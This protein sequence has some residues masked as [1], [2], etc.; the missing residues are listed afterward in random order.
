MSKFLRQDQSLQIK[1]NEADDY[2]FTDGEDKIGNENSILSKTLFPQVDRDEQSDALLV[3]CAGFEDTRHPMYDLLASFFTQK[4]FNKAQ[5]M[6]IVVVES[7][8]RMRLSSDRTAFMRSIKQLAKLLQGEVAAFRDS[9]GLVATKAD[10]SK[11]DEQLEKSVNVFLK[12][13]TNSLQE[14]RDDALEMGE[15][16]E[17]QSLE[18]QILLVQYLAAGDKVAIFRRPN[19][20]QS[21]WTQ[22]P[23]KKNFNKIRHLMLQNLHYLN[24]KNQK[25]QVSVAPETVIYIQSK[26]F[27][28]AEAKLKQILTDIGNSIILELKASSEKTEGTDLDEDVFK[29]RDS[30]VKYAAQTTA[31][32][33]T[34]SLTEYFRRS[35]I[36]ASLV[37]AVDL[38]MRKVEFLCEV[39]GSSVDS[40]R[41]QVT[42]MYGMWG[43]IQNYI[44]ENKNFL[45]AAAKLVEK[46]GSYKIYA[47][48][49]FS[50][51]V[52]SDNYGDFMMYLASLNLDASSFLA[53][54]NLKPT[55][56]QLNLLNRIKT[57]QMDHSIA[58]HKK[59][60]FVTYTGKYILATQI[61][62][63]ETIKGELVIMA[64]HKFFIDRD[65]TLTD[66]H[67]TIMAPI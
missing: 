58:I 14:K 66:T 7:F 22:T 46:S 34:S 64:T 25:F 49:P 20:K 47:S 8:E 44:D 19:D 61:E 11:P 48:P 52:S 17:V 41:S 37:N 56:N 54:A 29:M 12:S 4:V 33:S 15:I 65:L 2:I 53:A 24:T 27:V 13:T 59:N 62:S 40:F 36:D 38:E 6:K 10:S 39:V 9:I 45:I 50:A 5:K 32:N 42:A 16:S 26:L 63:P 21:P 18:R 35:N 57:E 3:D 28:A 31:I 67:V 60:N 43:N 30:V 51:I 1:Q 55:Q 23:L